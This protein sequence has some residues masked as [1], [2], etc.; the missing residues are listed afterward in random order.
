MEKT[1]H[2][3]KC[4]KKVSQSEEK[5]YLCT[6]CN[7]YFAE[8]TTPKVP[9]PPPRKALK[10]SVPLHLSEQFYLIKSLLDTFPPLQQKI[11]SAYIATFDHALNFELT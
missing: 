4:Y 7:L 3:P 8:I 10:R 6:A 1:Q 11:R 9:P 2:C 5:V